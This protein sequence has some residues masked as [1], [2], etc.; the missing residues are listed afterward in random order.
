MTALVGL[1]KIELPGNDILLCDGG[2]FSYD[3]DDYTDSDPDFGVVA[4]LEPITDSIGDSL[5]ILKISF[6]AAEGAAVATLVSSDMQNAR[7]RF[8]VAEFDYDTG[9]VT[10]TPDQVFDGII[11]RPVLQVGATERIVEFDV[12]SNAERLL[13]RSEA[14]SLSPRFHKSNWSG[15]LGMD[16]AIDLEIPVAWGVESPARFS[17]SGG[18]AGTD[19]RVR[20]DLQ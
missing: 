5:P 16:N 9:L 2:F 11:S 7:T 12:I 20:Y 15:E 13:L 17:A 18:G 6:A 14:N 19:P 4:G 8:Y 10:G 1:L 3:G